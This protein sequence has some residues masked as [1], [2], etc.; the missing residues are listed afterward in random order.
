MF[1]LPVRLS[2]NRIIS[3]FLTHSKSIGSNILS[4]KHLITANHASTRLQKQMLERSQYHD[5]L[6]GSLLHLR[7]LTVCKHIQQSQTSL[8]ESLMRTPDLQQAGAED[9]HIVFTQTLL[10]R[11]DSAQE[12]FKDLY[13]DLS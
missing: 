3:T 9:G 7:V 12:S 13:I 1:E 2:D 6:T 11:A 5:V 8:L 4:S 10:L